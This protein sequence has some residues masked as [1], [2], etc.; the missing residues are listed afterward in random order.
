MI[1][2]TPLKYHQAIIELLGAEPSLSEEAV[3]INRGT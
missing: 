2:D 3:R 1:N